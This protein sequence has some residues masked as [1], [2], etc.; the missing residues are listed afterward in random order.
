MSKIRSIS[1]QTHDTD[2]GRAVGLVVA[3]YEQDQPESL[4]LHRKPAEEAV[5]KGH[6]D[7]TEQRED[8]GAAREVVLEDVAI[9]VIWPVRWPRRL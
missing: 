9:L 2:Q 3:G 6:A 1:P 4:Q 7:V 8:V 5:I